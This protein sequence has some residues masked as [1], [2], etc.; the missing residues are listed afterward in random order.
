MNSFNHYA[1]GAVGEWI[2]ATVG[3]IAPDPDSPGFRS[4]LL[5]PRPGGGITHAKTTY[6]SPYGT[7]GL[8][9]RLED[10]SLT[11]HAEVPPNS[12]ARIVLD[13]VAAESVTGI[14][15]PAFRD[16]GGAAVATVGSG[17]YHLTCRRLRYSLR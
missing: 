3:G 17:R 14:V 9:W 8:E 1:Y 10:D 6:E 4:F 15:K 16:E 2:Y 5:A 11:L 12:T 7:I 13:G